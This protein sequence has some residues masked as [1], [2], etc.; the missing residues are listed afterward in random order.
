M[1]KQS[2][3]GVTCLLIMAIAPPPA[4]IV[5]VDA[6]DAV[7]IPSVTV[8]TPTIALAQYNPC[9]NGRCR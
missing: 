6:G 2:F 9:P 1:T 5:R 8:G 7:S 3:I 4:R